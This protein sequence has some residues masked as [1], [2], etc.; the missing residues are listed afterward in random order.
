MAQIVN[1]FSQIADVVK[2]TLISNVRIGVQALGSWHGLGLI[3][4]E[5]ASSWPAIATSMK[6]ALDRRPN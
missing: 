2:S 1:A 4:G 3:T 6:A 5:Y